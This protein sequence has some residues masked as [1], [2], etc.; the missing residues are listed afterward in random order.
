MARV[1]GRQQKGLRSRRRLIVLLV[2][3]VMATSMHCFFR[4]VVTPSELAVAAAKNSPRGNLSDLYPRWYGTRE[5][6][7]H[8][9]DPYSAEVTAD[10]QRGVWGRTLDVDK[11]NDPRDE[12]RFA[13]PL[14]IVFL[15]AP[16]V[17][18]PFS[19]A[20]MLFLGVGIA[21]CVASVWFWLRSFGN[22]K[23]VFITIVASVLLLGSYPFVNAFRVTQP[24]LILL[25]LI[26]GAIMAISVDWLFIAGIML[27]FAT[28]KPQTAIGIVAW[29]LFWACARWRKRKALVVSFALTFSALVLGAQLLLPGW[30][31]EWREGLSAYMRYAPGPGP[32]VEV[33]FGHQI[34]RVVSGF[35]IFGVGIFCWRTRTGPAVTDRF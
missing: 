11:P 21:G 31:W 1:A 32:Y 10:I 4:F 24:G 14:H 7:L 12:A 26:A 2:A 18:L 8:N 28:I 22:S 23:P 19:A 30:F 13:Y 9:R 15:L 25:P 33:I 5:L 34:G 3:L 27:A 16:T 29:L 17:V 6:L 35:V 20:E